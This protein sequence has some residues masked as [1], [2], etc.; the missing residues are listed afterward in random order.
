MGHSICS[1]HIFLLISSLCL[2][3]EVDGDFF[4]FL[5]D[6]AAMAVHLNF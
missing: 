3:M 4:Y 5:A 1:P 6:A 2:Q